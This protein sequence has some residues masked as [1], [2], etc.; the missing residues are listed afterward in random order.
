[1]EYTLGGESSRGTRSIFAP[2]FH[3][4]TLAGRRHRRRSSDIR[5]KQVA[6]IRAFVPA[7]D[8]GRECE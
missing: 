8:N 3:V 5:G 7:A 4:R 1:M 6:A 2:V